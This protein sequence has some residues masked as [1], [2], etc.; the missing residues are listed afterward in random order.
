MYI[1]ILRDRRPHPPLG[2]GCAE[3]IAAPAVLPNSHSPL[4]TRLDPHSSAG[5]IPDSIVISY[6]TNST[7]GD[8]SILLETGWGTT[9]ATG[10]ATETENNIGCPSNGN[11]GV[12]ARG[13]PL[14]SAPCCTNSST[15]SSPLCIG[16]PGCTVSP[17][18]SISD[19]KP[20]GCSASPPTV[21]QNLCKPR[22][23][24]VPANATN[25]YVTTTWPCRGTQ[26]AY[27]IRG[28][29]P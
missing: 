29:V 26:W 10:G 13:N 28:P 4:L 17:V 8:C 11:S 15:S 3:A 24:T 7:G 27:I 22:E 5:F 1:F 20:P 6:T 25:V 16:R 19:D 18:T 12:V 9:R 14:G 21:P 2:H 23:F